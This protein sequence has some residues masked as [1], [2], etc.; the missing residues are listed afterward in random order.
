MEMESMDTKF[1][2]QCGAEYYAHVE[3]CAACEIPLQTAPF[4]MV[5]DT[6]TLPQTPKE[7]APSE[8]LSV[9]RQAGLDWCRDLAD[10]LVD[11]GVSARVTSPPGES[12]S[13]G[14]CGSTYVVV[15]RSVDLDRARE[16][17]Q[18]HLELQVPGAEGLRQTA[19]STSEC[20]A[21][22]T[23]VG[24]RDEECPDCG[25]FI[26]ITDEDVEEAQGAA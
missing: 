18:R 22:G 12:C 16:L 26:G 24:A 21:C 17:D 4:G 10:F 25:L 13:T 20:P 9:V 19:S 5:P 14:G 15:V 2:P 6:S 3:R 8:S 23:A 1:C 11:N 7:F